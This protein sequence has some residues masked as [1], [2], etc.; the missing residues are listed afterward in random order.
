MT[1]HSKRTVQVPFVV[2]WWLLM[3]AVEAGLGDSWPTSLH[4]ARVSS[5]AD[6]TQSLRCACAELRAKC[7]ATPLL[8]AR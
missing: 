6:S 1:S 5:K 2:G 3:F 8:P 4:A 7:R